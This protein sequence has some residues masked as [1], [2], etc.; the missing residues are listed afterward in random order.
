MSE[1]TEN[2]APTQR[3]GT[4]TSSSTQA[5]NPVHRKKSTTT[6]AS[7]VLAE[8]ESA[9]AAKYAIALGMS[10]PFDEV[11]SLTFR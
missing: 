6:P 8:S 5:P 4:S 11:M 10:G 1:P 7:T 2:P 9:L 3:Q